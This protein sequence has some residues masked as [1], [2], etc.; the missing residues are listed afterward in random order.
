MVMRGP[1]IDN[2]GIKGTFDV[3]LRWSDD[4]AGPDTPDGPPPLITAL[5]ETLGLE[6][7]QGRG[8][9]DVLVIQHIE[10]PT[11]N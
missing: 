7:K 11:S 3:K 6:L 2:T 5:R 8:P 10:K 1:V 4:L 9:V